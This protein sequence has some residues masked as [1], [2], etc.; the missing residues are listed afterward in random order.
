[1]LWFF[2]CL[3]GDVSGKS[4]GDVAF[5]EHHSLQA[6]IL[7]KIY[8]KAILKEHA[9]ALLYSFKMTLLSC[10]SSDLNSTGWAQGWMAADFELLCADGRRAPLSEWESC[11]LGVIPPNTIMTRPVLTARVYDFL[12][13]SQVRS[14]AQ[15]L[16]S[17]IVRILYTI[18]IHWHQQNNH[19][20]QNMS[21]ILKTF[22]SIFFL[23]WSYSI[24]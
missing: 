13:K 8:K 7:S 20:R 4:Y 24:L 10:W 23:I 1:M 9:G 3:V 19:C 15:T 11:N 5:I 16:A 21:I 14:C 12:M 18:S 22:S 6:N 17:I 2:R